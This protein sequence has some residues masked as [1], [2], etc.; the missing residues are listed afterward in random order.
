MVSASPPA[1]SPRAQHLDLKRTRAGLY[2]AVGRPSKRAGLMLTA[3]D[4][5]ALTAI[6][7]RAT[8]RARAVQ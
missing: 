1:S 6:V 2:L 7:A 5:G 8:A 4:A 3:A